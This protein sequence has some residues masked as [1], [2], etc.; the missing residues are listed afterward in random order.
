MA[1]RDNTLVRQ[2]KAAFGTTMRAGRPAWFGSFGGLVAPHD[3]SH[4]TSNPIV[5]EHNKKAFYKAALSSSASNITG[6]AL[7][8]VPRPLEIN[9]NQ[10]KSPKS[11]ITLRVPTSTAETQPLKSISTC[12]KAIHGHDEME[13]D[14]YSTSEEQPA[15]RVKLTD[16]DV[17]TLA[18]QLIDDPSDQFN[19]LV[20]KGGAHEIG[21]LDHNEKS[22]NHVDDKSRGL[23]LLPKKPAFPTR[24]DAPAVARVLSTNNK[25]RLLASAI[26]LVTDNLI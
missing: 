2:N 23:A 24:N 14:D 5:L 26:D 19:N 6:S 7:R 1:S 18:Q 21:K 10:S 12:N 15:K 9:I 8:M 25:S 22:S 3:K 17:A 13:C 4:V 11:V 16:D 20:G